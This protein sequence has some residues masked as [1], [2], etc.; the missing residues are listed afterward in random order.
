MT[1]ALNVDQGFIELLSRAEFP[2]RLHLCCLKSVSWLV[3]FGYSRGTRWAPS[4]EGRHM[5]LHP[6]RHVG[7]TQSEI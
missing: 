6:S 1:G 7:K 3:G 4:E 5:N 2:P